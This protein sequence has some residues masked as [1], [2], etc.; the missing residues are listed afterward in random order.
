MNLV[1]N[2]YIKFLN[3]KG[4]KDQTG[5]ELKEGYY[6]YD[7]SIIKAYDT[8]GNIHKVVR[9]KVNNDLSISFK[10]YKDKEFEIESWRNTVNRKRQ[11]LINL[12]YKAFR[13]IE[14][15]DKYCS[16][17]IKRCVLS[18]GGKDSSVVTYLA[19]EILK[20]PPLIIFNNTTLDCAETY[21]H[22]KKEDNL[23]IIN[24]KEGF[25]QWRERMN[26]I[27]TRFSR[28][29]CNIFKEGA[30]TDYLEENDKYLF[31]MGMRNQESSTRSSY[32]D[33]WKNTKWGKRSWEA[34]LPIR[35]WSEED[36]WLYTIFRNIEVNPKYKLVY[37]RVGC[38]IACP[39]YTK[40]TWALDQYWYSN[41]YERWHKILEK[42]FIENKKAC[43]LNCTLNE[44]HYSWNGG[45]VHEEPSE[46]CIKE[47]SE[48]QGLELDIAKKYFNK[49]C[50]CC[51]KKLKKDD[52]ALSMKFYGRQIEKFKCIKCM[53]KELNTTVKELRERAKLFKQGGC[54]LF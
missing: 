17:D 28:A 20:N 35:T 10:R 9:L 21:K 12:E 38:V 8:N 37:S 13:L 22:I 7:K 30:M 34:M 47:F 23:L 36:V 18:S 19:K 25:Y 16:K 40:L 46:E 1:F 32:G 2:E 31:F 6:W 41:M 4:L 3:D 24:P 15:C 27:P 11:Y 51:N 42:D 33:R 48:Q 26:F 39:F 45:M 53:S 14:L 5:I 29:C 43:V 49:T 44:Y 52:I 54:T 50:V